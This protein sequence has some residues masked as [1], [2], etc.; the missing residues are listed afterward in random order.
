MEPKVHHR[1]HKSPPPVLILSHIDPV[2]KYD[3]MKITSIYIA[4]FTL[5]YMY[6]RIKVRIFI[7]GRLFSCERCVANLKRFKTVKE[8]TNKMH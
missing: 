7:L 4:D 3:V 5:F 8:K 6:F 2:A 1:I